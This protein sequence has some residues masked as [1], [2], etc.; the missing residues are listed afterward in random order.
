MTGT[1]SC[2]PPVED[3]L[4]YQFKCI[5]EIFGKNISRVSDGTKRSHN[6]EMCIHQNSTSIC[7]FCHVGT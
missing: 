1:Q 4:V 2:F 7:L 6:T 3:G 5:Y